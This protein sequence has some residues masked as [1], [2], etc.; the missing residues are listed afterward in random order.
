MLKIAFS[1]YFA[2]EKNYIFHVIFNEFLGLK[3]HVEYHE[4]NNYTIQLEN[5][6]LLIFSDSFFSKHIESQAYLFENNLPEKPDF[7]QNTFTKE[8]DIPILF[9]SESFEI[10]GEKNKILSCGNDIFAAAFF[11]LTRWEECVSPCKDEH[12][13]FPDKQAYVIKHNL[14]H[15]PIVN[16]YVEMLWNMLDFLGI[17]QKRKELKY[18]L[19]PT[20]D[21]DFFRRFVNVKQLIRSLAADVLKRKSIAQAASTFSNYFKTITN[22]KKDDFDTFDFL[23]QISEKQGLKSHFY[24]IAGLKT[25]L[26]VH[27]NYNTKQLFECIQNIEN[28]GHIVGIHGSYNSFNDNRTFNSELSRLQ[29]ISK[30]VKIGRQ[31]YLRFENPQTWQIWEANKM[32]Y[33]SSLAFSSEIGFRC[34]VCLPF[35][36]F[37]VLQRKHLR[38]KELPLIMMDSA[39]RRKTDSPEEFYTYNKSLSDVVRKYNGNF[40]I[41]WH[42]SNLFTHQWLD[43]IDVYK[44]IIENCS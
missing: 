28:K 7:E 27:Y 35:S 16:E 20:H 15:R 40:C 43:F 30:S 11:M 9:G 8:R 3:Y 22:K 36:V 34:G 26:D 10:V 6:N 33:D 5:G 29:T 13:R 2:K 31:H 32:Q 21:I 14:Q 19:I 17:K 39:L 1:N 24:F 38:L 4:Q 18:K 25:E 37:D 41:L 23:M 12:L 44:M 42:N